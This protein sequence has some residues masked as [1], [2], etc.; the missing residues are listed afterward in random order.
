MKITVLD[1][2]ILNPGDV[3]WS[4]L[5]A[6]GG[7]EVYEDTA[8]EEVTD[9]LAGADV[10]LV[11]KVK[12]GKPHIGALRSC[13]LVG[14]LATGVNNLDLP[15]LAAAGIDVCNVRQYG[16][17]DVAQHGLALLMEICR[18]VGA[19][20]ESV[21]RGEWKGAGRWCYWLKTPVC[22]C[23]K[24]MGIV[25]FGAI[26][27]ACGRI[28]HALGMSLLAYSP[29]SKPDPGYQPFSFASLDALLAN[30]DVISLHCPLSPATE[31]L[32][33]AQSIAS[34]RKGVIIIN[35]SRGGLVD[36]GAVADALRSGQIGGYGADV[37]AQ[38]PPRPDNP[39]FS[40]PNVF[41]TPHMAWAT[42]EARQKIIDIMADNI[43]SWLA[44]NL[45]NRV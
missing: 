13:G 4:P 18:N 15:A 27:Q 5:R 42:R 16:V 34:M 7:L 41:I 39:L 28:A 33:N 2:G 12:L 38:E 23:G 25:G 36:E 30:S 19:H 17:E 22:L 1:G 32:I 9:R 24:T 37:L 26:G 43:S 29:S 31:R 10:V 11:N 8:P 35:T 45:R 40:A 6:L 14:A 21:R 3:D 20:A 44:G